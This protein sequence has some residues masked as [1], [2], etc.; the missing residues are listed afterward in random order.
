M[1]QDPNRAVGMGTLKTIL[2]GMATRMGESVRDV[3][4]PMRKEMAQMVARLDAM[5][6]ELAAREYKGVFDAGVTYARGASV[7]YHGSIWIAKRATFDVPGATDGWQ[8]AV[9]AGRNGR[10][11]RD[12]T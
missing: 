3:L 7:T 2:A 9:K 11:A 8:L 5:E 12:G 10:D 1:N 6:A 4:L